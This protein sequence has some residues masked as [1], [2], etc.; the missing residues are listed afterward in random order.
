[1]RLFVFAHYEAFQLPQTY[2]EPQGLVLTPEAASGIFRYR[3]SAGT[4]RSVNLYQIAGAARFPSTPDPLIAK[5]LA[6]IAELTN[7]AA[8]LKSRIASNT[9]YNR[10]SI[11]FQSKGGNYRRFGTTRF[12]YNVTQKH[13]VEF[14]WNYQTNSRRPDGINLTT[15]SPVFP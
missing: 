6:T 11:D 4:V 3:D 10:S 7:G 15:A 9:D 1:N 13:H 8:G 14:V 12:D 5:S 2:I